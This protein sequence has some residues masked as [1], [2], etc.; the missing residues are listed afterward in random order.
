MP[1]F[2]VLGSALAAI[3]VMMIII[4]VLWYG[5]VWHKIALFAA[6]WVIVIVL[7]GMGI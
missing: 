1:I 3:T 6:A 5:E 2:F 7:W 4:H